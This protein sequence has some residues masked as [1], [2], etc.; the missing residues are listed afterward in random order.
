MCWN[1]RGTLQCHSKPELSNTA[2]SNKKSRGGEDIQKQGLSHKCDLTPKLTPKMYLPPSGLESTCTPDSFVVEPEP[3]LVQKGQMW[4]SEI[5][6]INQLS[7]TWL[8]YT[9]LLPFLL[10]FILPLTV[11]CLNRDA[12]AAQNSTGYSNMFSIMHQGLSW[13]A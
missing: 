9:P 2:S 6:C 10:T 4:R 11:N 13:Q 3:W 8:F 7:M 12:A 1:Q 5:P